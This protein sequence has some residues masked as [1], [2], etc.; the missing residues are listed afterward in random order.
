[1]Q[2]RAVNKAHRTRNGSREAE[3]P[4][5]VEILE[6]IAVNSAEGTISANGEVLDV[7]GIVYRKLKIRIKSDR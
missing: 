3:S 4:Q 2:V 5:P 6:Y 1:M 7:R